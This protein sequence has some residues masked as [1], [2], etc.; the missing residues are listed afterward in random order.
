M[1][2]IDTTYLSNLVFSII[3]PKLT[4]IYRLPVGDDASDGK[5]VFSF[6]FIQLAYM[7]GFLKLFN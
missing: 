4:F 2:R 7:V 1:F 5:N 3:H 6:I